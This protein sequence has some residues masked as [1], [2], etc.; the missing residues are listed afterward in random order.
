[1]YVIKGIFD[2]GSQHAVPPPALHRMN[3]NQHR[4]GSDDGKLHLE[5]GRVPAAEGFSRSCLQNVAAPLKPLKTIAQGRLLADSAVGAHGKLSRD[6]ETDFPF[7]AGS[8]GALSWARSVARYRAPHE[9]LAAC[10]PA[11][12]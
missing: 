8:A 1:M 9:G 4:R 11:H 10:A 5:P 7:K 3:D 6:G 12:A 2:T